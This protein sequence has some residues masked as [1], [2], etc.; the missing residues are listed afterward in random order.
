M[1]FP[2]LALLLAAPSSALNA[3]ERAQ[4]DDDVAA[5]L[6]RD[7]VP[8]L[9]LAIV[10][11][12]QLAYVKAYGVAERGTRAAT[13]ATRF[14]IGSVTE[15][16]TAAALLRLVDQGKLSLD[17]PVANVLPELTDAAHV[18]VRELLSHTSGYRDCFLQ[19]YIPAQMQRPTTVDAI[20]RTWAQRPRPCCTTPANSG[21]HSPEPRAPRR[22]HAR[23]LGLDASTRRHHASRA[24]ALLS[25]A[26]TASRRVRAAQPSDRAV[27]HRQQALERL[28]RALDRRRAAAS[29]ARPPDTPSA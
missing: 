14:A 16:F 9:S 28:P 13:P 4:V 2:L 19:E 5:I 24:D 15:A 8:G 29:R 6:P 25:A 7:D 27:L 26:R 1:L 3:A 22:A 18:M 20:L 17:D 21:F 11:G 23:A 12:G 10:R